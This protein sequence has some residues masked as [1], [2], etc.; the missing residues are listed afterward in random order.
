MRQSRHLMPSLSNKQVAA[1]SIT[2][3][4]NLLAAWL[5]VVFSQRENQ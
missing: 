1:K 4:G 5:K 2:D 3:C